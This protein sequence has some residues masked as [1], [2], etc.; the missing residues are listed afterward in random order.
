MASAEAVVADYAVKASEDRP[1]WLDQPAHN[2]STELGSEAPAEI[3]GSLTNKA[4][5]G[6]APTEAPAKWARYT[7]HVVSKRTPSQ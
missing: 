2:D 1:V 3:T 5:A 4:M 7:L 6:M